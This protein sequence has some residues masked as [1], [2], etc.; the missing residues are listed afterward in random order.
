MVT[1]LGEVENRK[2]YAQEIVRTLKHDGIVSVSEI[3][4]DP[5]KMT[6]EEVISLFKTTGLECCQK[7]ETFF[8]TTINFKKRTV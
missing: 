6:E 1:V 5:D 8:G 4:G 7:F 2:I 3:K